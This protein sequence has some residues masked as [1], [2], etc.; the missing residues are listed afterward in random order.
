MKRTANLAQV[1]DTAVE[2]CRVNA[3]FPVVVLSELRP[4]LIAAS[5]APFEFIP[6]R[7]HLPSLPPESYERYVRR[8]WSLIIAKWDIS[9]EIALSS[10]IDEFLADQLEANLSTSSPSSN[11]S[12]QRA[13]G[14]DTEDK[15]LDR[16]RGHG[17]T[18]DVTQA[19]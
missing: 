19:P 16:L 1:L 5:S 13:V 14:A 4:D 10:T 15:L 6:T 9:S 7:S 12:M 18:I 17:G 8:R 11:R 3:E 2:A